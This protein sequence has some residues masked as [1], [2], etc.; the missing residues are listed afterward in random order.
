[1]LTSLQ[2]PWV[3]HVRKLRQSKMRR[4]HQQFLLEGTHLLQEAIAV[5]YPL[6]AIHYTPQ[7]CDRNPTLAAS[8]GDRC[9]RVEAVS[10]EVLTAMAT[11]VN[12]DGVVAVAQYQEPNLPATPSFWIAVETLQDPGNLGTLIRTAAAVEADGL[13]LSPDSV[14]PTSPKVVRASA[15][16]WLRLPLGISPNWSQQ[17]QQWRQQGVQVVGTS[18]QAPTCFWDLDLRPPTVILL[19][20]E[21]AGLSAASRAQVSHQVHIPQGAGVESLNVA[22]AAALMLYEVKRQRHR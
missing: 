4:S 15:G 10:P 6:V 20:N 19:G 1:M 14:D 22:I 12:P 13:W 8:L 18:A 7:W 17:L 16:Q 9:P 2:N 3:K 11:T 21:G 5:D